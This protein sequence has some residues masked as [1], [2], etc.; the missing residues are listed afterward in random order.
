MLGELGYRP[1]ELYRI[2]IRE[3]L[4]AIEG[5][6][7]KDL[8]HE[9]WLKRAVT[10]IACTNWGGQ[11]I[12]QNINRLWPTR[13]P[14]GVKKPKIDIDQLRELTE[15][16]RQSDAYKRGKRKLD[17]RRSKSTGRRGN[18]ASSQSAT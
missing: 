4:L 15:R 10:I 14:T 16:S 1:W 12:P 3:A 2:T 8:L 18:S 13:L 17:A 11:K 5:L 9:S 7:D 6:R